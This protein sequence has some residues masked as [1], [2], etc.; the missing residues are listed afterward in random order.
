MI[1]FS[2]FLFCL[3]AIN[4]K[5]NCITINLLYFLIYFI[6]KNWKSKKNMQKRNFVP[7]EAKIREKKDKEGL[8]LMHFMV[9]TGKKKEKA[10]VRPFL[11]HSK[12]A[13]DAKNIQL[14]LVKG[15]KNLIYWL[16]CVKC[17]TPG[18]VQL[19]F[20]WMAIMTNALLLPMKKYLV[21][22]L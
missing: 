16:W 19:Y 8:A 20:K 7:R 15:S 11:P 10:K 1:K 2:F 3:D 6:K 18:T 21:R 12:Q 14:F 9:W 4:C 5:T 13:F 17:V 22:H